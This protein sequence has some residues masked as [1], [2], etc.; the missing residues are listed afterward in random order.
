MS[1]GDNMSINYGEL[2]ILATHS[3]LKLAKR[4]ADKFIPDGIRFIKPEVK[5]FPD[6]EIYVR[7]PENVRGSDLMIISSLHS[8]GEI[9]PLKELLFL[10][11][12][13]ESAYR[14]VVI[15]PYCGYAKQDRRVQPR[16]ADS[17]KVIAKVLS[18]SGINRIV[19]FDLHN[20]TCRGFF[21]IET[22]HLY[23]MRLLIEEAQRRNFKNLVIASPDINSGKRA[24]AVAKLMKIH[25]IC[26]VYKYRD[27]ITKKVDE[28]KSKPLGIVKGK[29]VIIFD[30]MVQ[31]GSTLTVAAKTLKDEGA[32]SV[33]AFAVHP[34]LT[35]GAIEK[36]SSSLLDEIVMVDT[37]PYDT[38]NWP[39]KIR[40][41]DPSQY[42]ADC[43]R[44]IHHNEPLSPLILNY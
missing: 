1:K 34:D 24:E 42:I 20:S 38:S 23:L 18:N 15:L 10:V 7:I 32:I 33:R 29:N 22:D 37:I 4:V 40:L 2:K 11:N 35:E 19:L 12:A 28:K 3:H 13:A 14:R 31:G 17:F 8:R 39:K 27:P 6:S 44:K 43:I 21:Q 5:K 9:D 30:D 25:N 16:E 41:V 36:L 26:I